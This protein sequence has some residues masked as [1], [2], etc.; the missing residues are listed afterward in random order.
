MS[1]GLIVQIYSLSNQ[2]AREEAERQALEEI[3]ERLE[4]M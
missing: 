3:R 4:N 2:P 1:N